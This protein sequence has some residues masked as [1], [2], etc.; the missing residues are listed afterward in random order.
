MSKITLNIKGMPCGSCVPKIEGNVGKLNGVESVE[1]HLA[2]SKVDV[3]FDPNAVSLKEIT[4]VIE[5]Q[6][7]GIEEQP[8]KGQC[9][10]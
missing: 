1:V 9:C 10:H 8:T 3:T 6:G 4:D 7:Y 5:G 2:E